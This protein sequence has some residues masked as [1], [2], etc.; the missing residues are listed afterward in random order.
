MLDV[1]PLLRLYAR[2][3]LGVLAR[4]RP[5][6]AQERLLLGLVRRARGTRFGRD[7][8]FAGIESVA[9]FQTRV[10]IRSYED[11]W[12]DYWGDAFPHLHELTW[13]GAIPCFAETSG[14]TTGNSKHIPLSH[15]MLRQFRKVGID[16]L[17]FH[18]ANR[19]GSRIMGGRLFMLGG[20]TNLSEPGPGIRSGF[21]SGIAAAE[22]PWW[23]QPWRFP[24]KELAAIDDWD[25]KIEA[26]A[27]HSLGADIRLLGGMTSWLLLFL[28][29]VSRCRPAP[30]GRLTEWYPDLEMLVFGG[31]ALH[32]YRR[33]L[34][35]L[36]EG[37][38]AELRE[39][40]PAS[41]GF[42]A[43]ADRDVDDGLRLTLDAG[44][45]YEFVPV[46]E[47]GS[48]RPT[49]LW[50]SDA[51]I[52]RD[53][54]IVLSS[55]AGLWSYLLGDIVRF[56]DLD[57][58]RLIVTGRTSYHL[59]SFGEHMTGAEIENAIA[60][61]AA[62]IGLHVAD[63][64][65]GPISPDGHDAPGH[66][67][68]VVEFQE[69]PPDEASAAKFADRLDR[70]LAETNLS[71]A[72]RRKGDVGLHPPEVIV[73]KPGSFADWMRQRGKLGGQHKVPRVVNDDA[74]LRSLRDFAKERQAAD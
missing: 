10:P 38:K 37:G 45:F 15:E 20:S 72:T 43:V 18:V 1:T 61:A 67:L 13:P 34:E 69:K 56:V 35:A 23:I 26:I 3:R 6:E 70:E 58:P 52:G 22:S 48:E 60:A 68:Y 62:A 40:Y 33:R 2:W 17:V 32:P 14:T 66:H 65:V 41:E 19:P 12:D 49:R 54:A 27:P 57:P 47:L 51:E 53:Y 73:L 63:F 31:M 71:Y 28:E 25:R 29:S 8:D 74:L 7:H 44:L 50:I 42:I 9:D 5:A 4:Q 46:E 16:L 55:C 30:S 36:I 39:V 24:P 59:S 64:S 21:I 11:F